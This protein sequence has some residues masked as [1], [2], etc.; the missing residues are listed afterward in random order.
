MNDLGFAPNPFHG[1]C[2]LLECKPQI[3]KQAAVGDW[4]IGLS[5]KT[6]NNKIVFAMEV[7]EKMPI[8][9]YWS[10][11]RFV[12]K[13]PDFTSEEPLQKCGDNI[14]EPLV[15]NKFAQMRSF[16]KMS[17]TD[18]R[19]HLKTDLSGKNVLISSNY[20]YFGQ[21]SIALPVMLKGLIIGRGH[22]CCFLDSFVNDVIAYVSKLQKPTIFKPTHIIAN[23]RCSNQKTCR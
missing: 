18:D 16:H 4:V 11:E 13:R 8:S 6:S 20:W 23:N 1:Y 10:D 17:H 21:D 15:G 22:R 5:S 3:R 14:Y 2:T 12:A 19:D 7:T 9:Q